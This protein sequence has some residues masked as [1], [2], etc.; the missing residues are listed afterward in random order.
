MRHELKIWSEYYDAVVDGRKKFEL[1]SEIDRRFEPGDELVLRE[2]DKRSGKHTGNSCI[3]AV[4][5]VHRGLGLDEHFA[6]MSISNV[7][8]GYGNAG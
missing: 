5:Y 6:C 8:E 4:D 2:V 1:R 3:A 7:R